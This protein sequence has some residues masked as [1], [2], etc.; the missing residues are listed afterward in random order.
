MSS[1]RVGSQGHRVEWGERWGIWRDKQKPS[2]TDDV[3]QVLGHTWHKESAPHL[4]CPITEAAQSSRETQMRTACSCS[5]DLSLRGSSQQEPGYSRYPGSCQWP[6]PSP[7]LTSLHSSPLLVRLQ[8]NLP[9]YEGPCH[10]WLSNGFGTLPTS[11]LSFPPLQVPALSHSLAPGKH[12]Y[13]PQL[14]MLKNSRQ[15]SQ[16]TLSKWEG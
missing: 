6:S 7:Y 16:L 15:R 5:S 9:G 14:L 1:T 12:P 11:S 13:L 2:S 10:P 4:S 3:C 8:T